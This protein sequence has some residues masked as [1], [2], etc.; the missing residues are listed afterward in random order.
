MVV[1][2]DVGRWSMRWHEGRVAVVTGGSR[3]IG[4]AIAARLVDDGATVV[5]SGRTEATL[6]AT[7]HELGVDTVH[8]VVA[9]ATGPD[10]AAPVEHALSHHGRV[11][12]L[13]NNVGGMAG[14]S[15]DLFT[16]D[17]E[18]FS[19]TVALNLSAAEVTTR[20]AVTCM[21]DNGFGRIINIGS[22]A[23]HRAVATLGYTA[24]KHGLVGLTKQLAQLLG[25]TG[26]TANC[27]FP[28]WTN[29]DLVDF[30]FVAARRGITAAEA[31]AEAENMSA[32]RR[33]I[34]PE[35]V[36]PLVSFLASADAAA[37]TGQGIGADGGFM[38]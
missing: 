6:A 29:T 9:D 18:A 7:A 27:V 20:A 8:T 10:A 21:R 4:R 16:G 37:I 13:V 1:E 36:A 14:G 22:G 23:S 15:H 11:D 19:A 33:I 32:Q 24:A 3:G 31:R 26:V 38:L 25:T 5:I 12:I 28:G 17:S 35:E 30:D 34:E 2:L